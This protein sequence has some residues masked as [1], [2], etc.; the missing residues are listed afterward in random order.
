MT[1][2]KGKPASIFDDYHPGPGQNNCVVMVIKALQWFEMINEV[3]SFYNM[4]S[5]HQLTA[6]FYCVLAKTNIHS[7]TFRKISQYKNQSVVRLICYQKK[8]RFLDAL[9]SLE[10]D[11]TVTD[12]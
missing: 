6:R 10:L 5:F 9:A 7:Q 4:L 8:G 2:K 3:L 12:L 11:I 1:G